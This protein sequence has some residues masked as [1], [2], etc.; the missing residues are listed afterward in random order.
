MEGVF[1]YWIAW[2]CWT[3]VTFFMKKGRTR[4]QLAAFILFIILF[5]GSNMNIQGKLFSVSLI[6]LLI[7]AYRCFSLY[8]GKRMIYHLFACHVVTLAYAGFFMY[9]MLDP[10]IVWGNKMWV[11]AVLIFFLVQILIDSFPMRIIV[12]VIGVSHGNILYEWMTRAFSGSVK[13]GSLS[14][15]DLLA[16]VVF[17]I[18]AWRLYVKAVGMLNVILQKALHSKTTAANRSR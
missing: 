8:G 13:I 3:F 5:S 1:F 12:A 2:I 9:S 10:V 4:T 14:F 7:Y 6:L 11:T 15:F 16:A 18:C 17:L